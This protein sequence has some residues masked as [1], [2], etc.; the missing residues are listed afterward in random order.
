[1][2]PVGSAVELSFDYAG[3]GLAVQGGGELVGFMVAGP[4]RR[5]VRADARIEGDKV[6]VSSP[7]VRHPVAVRY[8]RLFLPRQF[9]Q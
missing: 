5:F 4:D 6:V 1:M 8:G 9:V 7:E 2:K 3:S